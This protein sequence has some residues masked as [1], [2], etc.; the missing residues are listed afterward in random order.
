[1]CRSHIGSHSRFH[2]R[3]C[4]F[5]HHLAREPAVHRLRRVESSGLE[6]LI[7]RGAAAAPTEIA[8]GAL[9]RLHAAPDLV[10]DVSKRVGASKVSE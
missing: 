8:T 4:F 9:A 5:K 10:A 7:C 3:Y 6:Q 1:M 2:P